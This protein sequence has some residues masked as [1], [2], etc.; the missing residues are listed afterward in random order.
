MAGTN[1]ETTTGVDS[2]AIPNIML[3]S[4]HT[5]KI[6]AQYLLTI[7]VV[8]CINFALP[9]LAPGDAGLY[10]LGED[11]QFLA[12]AEKAKVLREFGLDLPVH[13]QFIHYWKNM[14]TGQWGYSVVYGQSVLKVLSMKV[15]FTLLLIGVSFLISSILAIALGVFSARKRGKTGDLG[16]LSAVMLTGS[17]P[18]FWLGM[19]LITFFSA[20]L[21]WFPSHGAVPVAAM[22]GSMDFY[23]GVLSRLV[24]PA[25]C[26][27]VY[28]MGSLYLT[29]RASMSATLDE[30]FV[31]LAYARGL[32]PSRVMNRH[33]LPNA[34]LPIFTNLMVSLGHLISGNTVV[35]TV[36][37]YP[38]LGKT[39]YESIYARDFPL[40]Q[41]I[42]LILSLSV[43]AANL[44][45]DLIYPYLAP[46]VRSAFGEKGE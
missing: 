11:Y 31:M 35:E 16:I 39:I 33:A 19:L 9:R 37:S 3:F 23:L 6:I 10:L 42:F 15:P 18:P 45:T 2:A 40:L 26:L 8:L 27:V 7:F 1:T 12:P 25:T 17:L 20:G 22:P 4:K 44:L 43:I 21:G 46:Q 14:F 28:Q 5:L 30:D 38:G 36:F 34:F 13:L 32:K 29:T 41:G 24:L